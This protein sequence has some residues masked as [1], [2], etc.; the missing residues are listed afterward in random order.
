MKKLI[1][2]LSLCLITICVYSQK[3]ISIYWDASY[4]MKDRNLS[5]E[6]QFLDNY[7]KA[8]P[9]IDIKLTMFSND[10][11]LKETFNVVGGDWNGLKQEL[12]NTVYDGATVYSNLFN[13]ATDEYLIFTDGIENM[14]RFKLSTTKPIRIISSSPNANIIEL[15]LQADLVSG[16]FVYL[17][18]Q[19]IRP[20]IKTKNNEEV[21]TNSDI[22]TS[23][24]VNPGPVKEEQEIERLSEV[25]V[26]ATIENTAMTAYG[27]VNRDKVGYASQTIGSEAIPLTATDA[28]NTIVGKFSGLDLNLNE[29]ISKFKGRGSSLLLSEHGLIVI[30][31]VPMEQTG[32][33]FGGTKGNVPLTL[34]NADAGDGKGPSSDPLSK[35]KKSQQHLSSTGSSFHAITSYLDP[36]IIESITLLK[37]L[38]ATNKYGTQGNNGVLVITTKLAAGAVATKKNDI[39]LGTT[40]TYSGNAEQLQDLP[41]V[42]YINRLKN[43][44]DV[45][46][47]FSI[48][49][50]ERETHGDNA[51]FYIDCHD[52]FKGWNNDLISS[53]VLSNVYEIGFD[54][55]IALRALAY[56]QQEVGNYKGAV[57]TLKRVLKLAPKQAQSYKDL[58]QALHFAN[59]PREALK[60]YNDIDKGLR[61]SNTNFAGIKKTLINDTK[62]LIFRHQSKVSTSSVNPLYLR[63]IKYK[64]RIIFEWN[65]LDAEFDLNIINPQKR[66]FTWSHT[67][68]ENRARISQEKMQGYGLEEFYLTSADVGEWTFNAKYY[69]K[70]SGKA[71]PTFVKITIFKNFG[72]PNQSKE[73]KVIRLDKQDIEQ[74]IAN[75]NVI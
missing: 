49:L 12:Q 2:I 22:A 27:E 59:E 75:I 32:V 43:A 1:S 28:T 5:K 67:N 7:F 17:T 25:K 60:I 4:S 74:T 48:Y 20:K 73:I 64:S 8:N 52:Y 62:N 65:D 69:G 42:A 39:P 50:Q 61:V 46:E 34:G 47:A 9:E 66:F 45:N 11:I 63:N 37:G 38:A 72:Q 21:T 31:G 23:N 41:D 29:D 14:N 19:M 70:T 24:L 18:D 13:D 30:D 16:S 26:T 40:A 68:V 56:K 53:R 36:Q 6:F 35:L 15:K 3:K 55:A 51:S 33:T 57:Q 10:I 44:V 71:T 58:A 54:D